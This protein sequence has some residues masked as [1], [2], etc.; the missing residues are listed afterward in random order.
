MTPSG[1]LATIAFLG[2]LFAAC[3]GD[4]PTGVSGTGQVVG[5]AGGTLVF[6]NNSVALVFPAGAVTQTVTITVRPAVQFP[7]NSGVI[8]GTVYELG[9]AGLQFNTQVGLGIRYDIAAV[10]PGVAEAE[11]TIGKVAGNDWQQ[12]AGTLVS[13]DE[14]V[15]AV[16]IDGFSV[17]GIMLVP[18]AAVTVSPASATLVL[19]QP[20]LLQAK[21][22]SAAGDTLRTRPVT[23]TSSNPLVATVDIGGLVTGVGEGSATITAT[24]EGVPGTASVSVAVLDFV[25]VTT[26]G[27]HSCGLVTGGAAYCWGYGSSLG[28]PP[29]PF[30]LFEN[31]SYPIAVSGGLHFQSVDGGQAHTC[32]V[33]LSAAAY[34]WGRG[35]DGQIGNGSTSQEG[36]EAPQLVS[37]G[38]TW[39]SVSAGF[40]HSCGVTTDSLAYCWGNN[41]AGAL[42]NGSSANSPTPVPVSA[43]LKWV[44]ISA[45]AFFSCG[46]A[47]DSTAYCWGYNPDGRLGDGTTQDHDVPMPIAG[48]LTIEAISTGGSYVCALADDHQAYCWGG[49]PDGALGDGSVSHPS[50]APVSGGLAF[51]TI[52]AGN[53]HSCGADIGSS[54]YCWGGNGSG[55]LGIGSTSSQTAPTPVTG[56]LSFGFVSSSLSGIS[57]HS[58]GITTGNK[59]YCWGSGERGELGDG[60]TTGA[61]APVRVIGQQ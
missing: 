3:G 52:S 57:A 5:P 25:S 50:P 17:Y 15:A 23:W 40:V 53:F 11:L 58:C 8:P 59:V 51:A 47:A 20:L 1:F 26:G 4:S 34:C 28:N 60:P 6:A 39:A 24:S 45:G 38:L 41:F 56:G 48:S 33:S 16:P 29:P 44:A 49:S 32:A 55:A 14:N 19:D 46:I 21:P 7:S 31:S 2:L 10:P 9:P 35:D 54:A 61:T 13:A 42:G 30:T 37:G 36:N 43:G 18:V 27:E 12:L 22:T